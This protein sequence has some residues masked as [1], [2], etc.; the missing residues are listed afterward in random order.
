MNILKATNKLLAATPLSVR[1]SDSYDSGREEIEQDT[2]YHVVFKSADGSQPT[3]SHRITTRIV[4]GSGTISSVG[5]VADGESKNITWTM[6]VI[7]DNLPKGVKPV[8]GSFRLKKSDG[9]EIVLADSV[10]DAHRNLISVFVGDI[11]GDESYTLIFD[12][13]VMPEAFESGSDIG[14]IG[15]AYGG[16]LKDYLKPGNPGDYKDEGHKIGDPYFP[17]N[18]GWLANASENTNSNK[19]YPLKKDV[20]DSVSNNNVVI[21]DNVKTGDEMHIAMYISLLAIS[22]AVLIL[23]IWFNRRKSEE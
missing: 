11:Y 13:K 22:L 18:D 1:A 12:A 7:R 5:S 23:C 21:G 19:T 2:N 6:A 20:P 17:A 16:N 8:V 9:S 4:G 10:Y 15:L 14:N 3:G